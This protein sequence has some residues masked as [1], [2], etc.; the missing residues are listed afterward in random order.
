[1]KAVV[2]EYSTEIKLSP[3]EFKEFCKP[4]QG[5]ETCVW[6]VVSGDGFECLYYNKPLSLFGRWKKGL[7][8]AKRNGCDKVKSFN[9]FD[10]D[11][12]IEF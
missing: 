8:S 6:A 1:M 12:E 5:V 4:G 7:T 3:E 2:N 10:S 11:G 9:S